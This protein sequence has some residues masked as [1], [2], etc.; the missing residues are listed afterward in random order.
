M[1]L[2]HFLLIAALLSLAWLSG[3]RQD[4][5]QPPLV[6]DLSLNQ[7]KIEIVQDGVYRM[8]LADL[9]D[10]GLAVETLSADNLMLRQGETAVA[11]TLLDDALVFYGEAPTSRYVATRSYVLST[12]EAG[13]TMPETAVTPADTF[14]LSVVPQVLH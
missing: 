14:T 5:P 2:R 7:V 6:G 1:D 10:A 9:Q 4:N 3:C 8:S 11:Y 12:G 13:D